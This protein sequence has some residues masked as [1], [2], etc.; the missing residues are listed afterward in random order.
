[1][2]TGTGK[3]ITALGA[4][5]KLKDLELVVISAPT[6]EI[7]QQWVEELA[8]R[9]SFHAPILAAGRSEDWREPLFRKLRL[10]KHKRLPREKIPLIVVGSYGELSKAPVLQLIEDAGGLPEQSLLIGDEVHTAG[11][12]SGR[13][14]ALVAIKCLDE[15]VDVPETDL[16][17]GCPSR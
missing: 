17:L 3:T 11:A 8:N 7:V 5:T 15:G 6:N 12:T 9:T 16:A 10:L 14:G 2:A 4:I 1:M 13:L